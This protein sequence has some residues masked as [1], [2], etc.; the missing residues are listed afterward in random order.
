MAAR[1]KRLASTGHK[2]PR[3]FAG[4]GTGAAAR[5]RTDDPRAARRPES[6]SR[7]SRFEIGAQFRGSLATQVAIFLQRLVDDLFQFGWKL[8]VYRRRRCGRVLQNL[9]ENHGRGVAAERLAPRPHFVENHPERKQVRAGVQS[10]AAGL[11][12]RHVSGGADGRART[13]QIRAGRGSRHS[14]LGR[15]AKHFASGD[16]ALLSRNPGFW[17]AHA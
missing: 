15:K 14:H 5:R 11:L 2:R 9:I 6:V 3:G 4:C 10:F 13:G 12:R 17:R 8:R 1:A 16:S 7:L